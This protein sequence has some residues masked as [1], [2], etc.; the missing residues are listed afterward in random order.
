[1]NF[2]IVA[3]TLFGSAGSIAPSRA[4]SA[5]AMA[6][7]LVTAWIW[8]AMSCRTIGAGSA[9]HFPAMVLAFARDAS[10]AW[11]QT[12]T[13]LAKAVSFTAS[14]DARRAGRLMSG[15]GGAIGLTA[16]VVA[17][18]SATPAVR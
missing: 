7:T 5:C 10:I 6:G 17:P 16:M 8:L 12:S 9:S 4:T 15:A 14:A 18:T 2:W 1:M 11:D 13:G 3:G